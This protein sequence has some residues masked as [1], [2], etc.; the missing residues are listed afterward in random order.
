MGGDHGPKVT[1]PACRQFL[2]ARPDAQLML[3]GQAEALAGFAHER[4]RVVPGNPVA[5]ELVRRIRGQ[6]RPRM[7]YDGPPYLTDAE[8]DLIVAWIEQGAR[9]RAASNRAGGRPST[10]AWPPG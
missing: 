1:W 8:I 2:D 5:S 6:A 9:C 7:P 4:A 3:V 10:S